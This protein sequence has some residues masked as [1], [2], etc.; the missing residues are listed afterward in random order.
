MNSTD[1]ASDMQ[2]SYEMVSISLMCLLSVPLT[3]NRISLIH[4]S[5][6]F[7]LLIK[8]RKTEKSNT[9]SLQSSFDNERFFLKFFEI[10]EFIRSFSNRFISPTASP[11]ASFTGTG[12]GTSFFNRFRR[13]L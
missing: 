7:I 10:N 13:F 6:V 3:F 9:L 2:I 12:C 5:K 4:A 8:E 1:R 11:A